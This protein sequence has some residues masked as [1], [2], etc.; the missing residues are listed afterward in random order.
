MTRLT[1]R[2][3]S[4]LAAVLALA[5][6]LP[7]QARNDA[8]EVPLDQALAKKRAREAIGDMPLRFGSAS[9]QGVDLLRDEIEA[10]GV[11]SVVQDDPRKHEH[12]TDAET[13]ALAFEQAIGKLAVQARGAQAAAVVGIV[14]AFKGVVVDD[15]AHYDCHAGS[16]KSYVTLRG[17]MARTFTQASA[18]AL[19][20]PTAFAALDDV[21]A[22]PISAAGQDRYAHFLTLPK[23]RAFVV[24][25]D[26]NWR[27]YSKDP[28]SMTKALDYCARQGKRCWLYAVDDRIVWSADIDKRIG[29]S[30]QLGGAPSAAA[31]QD[32]HQ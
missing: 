12:L 21:K 26:G 28:E 4:I 24:Y 29:N 2:S 31:A 1:S 22:V 11:A 3:L 14:S 5:A 20:A 23:P 32:E 17:R 16:A 30:A 6:A 7:A 15:P 9:A 27:F 8:I 19:P 10:D 13:C 25:E 18:R